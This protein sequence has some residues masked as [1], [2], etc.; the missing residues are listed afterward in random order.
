MNPRLAG[1]V[2]VAALCLAGA[3]SARALDRQK[4]LS[5]Y[6]LETWGARDGLK[7]HRV[8]AITQTRDGYLWLATEDGL[9]RFD[10]VRFTTFQ[11]KNSRGFGHDYLYALAEGDDGSLWIGTYH[12]LTR[13]KDGA[14]TTYTDAD[15]MTDAFVWCLSRGT[16][17]LWIGGWKG[18]SRFANGAFTKHP[19]FAGRSIRDVREARDGSLW[20]GA[21][22]TLHHLVEGREPVVYGAR[23]GLPRDVRFTELLEASDG[24]LWIG[25]EQGLGHLTA[26]GLTFYTA[27]DGL[28]GSNVQALL[29]DRDHNIWIGTTAGLSR[30]DGE[31]FTSLTKGLSDESIAALYEDR[32][33]SLWIGTPG[34]GLCR[35]KDGRF[36]PYGRAEGVAE[37]T[38]WFVRE[39]GDGSVWMG[40]DGGGLN[41]LKDGRMATY[42]SRD[43]LP[44]DI[45]FA[46]APGRDGV[47]WL[48]MNTGLARRDG[49]GRIHTFA[50]ES[51]FKSASV[52]TV[53]EDSR[54][55]VWA[56]TSSDGLYRRE[57]DRFVSVQPPEVTEPH[58]YLSS[59]IEGRDGSIWFGTDAGLWR[60]KDDAF[61][62]YTSKSGLPG[63][64]VAGML[65]EPDGTLWVG[66][67]PGGLG[68]LKAGRW[69]TVRSDAG[70]IDENVN[71]MLDDGVGHFWFSTD[72]AIYYVAKNELDAVADGR[73]Q[74]LVSHGFDTHDGLRVPEGSAGSPAV[75]KAADGRLWFATSRGTAVI[76]PRRLQRD[77][78]APPVYVE[79]LAVDGR[80][81]SL[82]EPVRVPPG[83][84]EMEI[85][86]TAPSLHIPERVRF[87]YRLEGF[88]A[89]W[90]DAGARR[91][92]YYTN[93]PPGRYRFRVIAS[94][95]AGLWNEAGASLDFELLPRFYQTRAFRASLA[96]GLLLAIVAIHRLRVRHLKRREQELAQRVDDGLARIKVLSGMLPI[97]ASCNKIRDEAGEWSRIEAYIEE[98]SQANFSHGVCP[99]CVKSLYPEYAAYREK[100]Q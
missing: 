54:G 24:S 40:T 2:L 30:F 12:G 73:A 25:S 68:R 71:A 16:G 1:L 39:T 27:R 67:N 41:R 3:D 6:V 94:N 11:K 60:L 44:D 51:G 49:Q 55:R 56:G 20:V 42:T 70:L 29:E 83:R 15:G 14:F 75:W 53:L 32:E 90:V 63:D 5:Q 95:D 84:G 58:V 100:M 35:L 38:V 50:T 64:Y 85:R 89:D 57:G 46:M 19:L 59:I 76:D 98:H 87:K 8:H 9:V 28:A 18:L 92:V 45:A 43:G 80:V 47:S 13:L 23:E 62:V 91:I 48:G 26:R 78:A 7:Q 36:T 81:V 77:S 88:D 4:A 37:N 31:R 17:R 10:G 52:R 86:Y 93:I 69:S 74:S 22:Q 65:E 97:C 79:G 34:G 96:A 33:G 61:T 21:G 72:R 66:T 82:K 99:D